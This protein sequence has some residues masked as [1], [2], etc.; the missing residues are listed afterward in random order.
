MENVTDVWRHFEGTCDKTLIV[1]RAHKGA[2]TLTVDVM[3]H[4]MKHVLCTYFVVL[5]EIAL[6]KNGRIWFDDHWTQHKHRLERDNPSKTSVCYDFVNPRLGQSRIVTDL[7]FSGGFKGGLDEADQMNKIN[8]LDF[9]KACGNLYPLFVT[10]VDKDGMFVVGVKL[11]GG[12]VLSQDSMLVKSTRT[13]WWLANG[14]IPSYTAVS[15]T[16]SVSKTTTASS[17][18]FA[19]G[20]RTDH[21]TGATPKRLQFPS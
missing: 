15:K 6:L 17:S 19:G 12:E 9:I 11:A 7:N 4:Y 1:L 16:T 3:K 5:A 14:P 13:S 21:T 20:V 2:Q 8:V 18:S 10:R